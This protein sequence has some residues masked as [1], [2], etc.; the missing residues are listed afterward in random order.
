M[1][2]VQKALY[3]FSLADEEQNAAAQ[4]FMGKVMSVCLCVCVCMCAC[5]CVRAHLYMRA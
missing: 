5:V 2:I 3:Y 4:G 1:S